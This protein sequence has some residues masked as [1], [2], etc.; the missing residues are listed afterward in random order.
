MVPGGGTWGQAS[1]PVVGREAGQYLWGSRDPAIG[2]LL[3]TFLTGAWLLSGTMLNK[4]VT[5]MGAF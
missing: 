2:S 4:Q 3:S 1:A 5:L